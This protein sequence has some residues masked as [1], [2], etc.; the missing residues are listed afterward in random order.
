MSDDH[1]LKT[2]KS[3]YFSSSLVAHREIWHYDNN[4]PLNFTLQRHTL[5]L[6]FDVIKRQ[7]NIKTKTGFSHLSL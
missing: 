6:I 7:K 3:Q 2:V 4:G 1:H 5:H